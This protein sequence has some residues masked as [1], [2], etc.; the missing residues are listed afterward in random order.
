MASADGPPLLDVRNLTK[1]FPVRGGPLAGR[2]A[3]V[4]AVDGV[5]FRVEQGEVLGVVGNP[6]AGNRRW[7]G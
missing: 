3:R 5:S 2:G 6:G 7:R 4:H 1:Y